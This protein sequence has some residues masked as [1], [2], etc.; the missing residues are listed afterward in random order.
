MTAG[1][2][3]R[4]EHAPASAACGPVARRRAEFWSEAGGECFSCS[5]AAS[6]IFRLDL[7]ISSKCIVGTLNAYEVLACR[8]LICDYII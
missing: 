6:L 7:A 3:P 2:C 1:A 4:R 5:S 8:N